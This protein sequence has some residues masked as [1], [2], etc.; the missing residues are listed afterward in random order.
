M[1]NHLPVFIP[2]HMRA[3]ERVPR[4]KKDT[5]PASVPVNRHSPRII[6]VPVP[7]HVGKNTTTSS[8][9]ASEFGLFP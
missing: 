5:R 7:A 8:A 2:H 1:D 4:V 6:P 3:R 9:V